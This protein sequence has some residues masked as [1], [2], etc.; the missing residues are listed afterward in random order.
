MQNPTYSCCIKSQAARKN[1]ETAGNMSICCRNAQNL[2]S[3]LIIMG[4]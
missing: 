3:N 1:Y 4:V 2:L